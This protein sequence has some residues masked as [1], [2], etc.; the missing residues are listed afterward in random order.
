MSEP[1]TDGLPLNV[2]VRLSEAQHERGW[3]SDETLAGIARETNTPLYALGAVT[4]FYPHYRR[5][6]PPA[7][8]V[9]VCRDA[10]CRMRGAQALA[11]DVRTRLAGRQ[12]VEV[13]EASCL[14]RCEVAP[15]ATVDDVPIPSADVATLEALALRRKPLPPD[16]PTASPR[17]WQTDPY[18]PGGPRY[19][20]LRRLLAGGPKAFEGVPAVLTEAGLQGMGGAGFPTGRKWDLV[21]AAGGSPTYVVCNAD[22]SEPCTF[23]DRVLLEELPHLVLEGMLVA[24]RVVGATTAIVYVRHEYGRETKALRREIESARADGVLGAAGVDV[25]VFVSPGGYILGEE[26]ALLEA[27]EGRRGE[28]RNKPPY[29][30]THG[31]HGKPTLMNNVETFAHVPRILAE[32]GATWRARGT[33]GAAG[34]KFMALAGDVERPGVYEIPM[35]TPARRLVELGGGVSGG[36]KPLAFCPGGAS[37]AFLPASKLDAPLSWDGMKAAGSALGSGAM[38][39]VA[40]GRDLLDLAASGVRFFRNESCGKCVPCRVGSEKAAELLDRA[41]AGQASKADLE[42]LR[43]LHETLALTSICGLGMV[44]LVPAMSVLD[45]FP[46]EVDARLSRPGPSPGR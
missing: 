1:G 2:L 10:A 6:P 41:L 18:G 15:A 43:P 5:S 27:L 30:G 45:H 24:C 4:S 28:P 34:L 13:R 38:L 11:D 36:R 19:G 16:E 17:R 39:V 22:E 32:G 31:L 29:P 25:T 26:T 14:G 21:R 9:S 33:N 7:C 44:A 46:A 12:D 35:G 20:T 8:S 3:L 23:K 40:E 37:T 42:V